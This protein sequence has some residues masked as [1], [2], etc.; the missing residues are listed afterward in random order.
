VSATIGL[1]FDELVL[2]WPLDITLWVAAGFLVA[3]RQGNIWGPVMVLIG[4]SSI[5]GLVLSQLVEIAV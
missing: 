1:F 3:R 5:Y 2:A 4:I